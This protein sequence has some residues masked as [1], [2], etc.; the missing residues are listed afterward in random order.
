MGRLLIAD[1]VGDSGC[2]AIPPAEYPAYRRRRSLSRPQFTGERGL[3]SRAVSVE[4]LGVPFEAIYD[5][6]VGDDETTV[7]IISAWRVSQLP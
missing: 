2:A 5:H 7:C 3:E 6:P 4:H 1:K